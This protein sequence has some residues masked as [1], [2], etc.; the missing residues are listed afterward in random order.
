[1]FGI[2][3]QP[4]MQEQQGQN[5][6]GSRPSGGG[7]QEAIKVLS[8]RLPK[9][10]GAHGIAPMP[11]LTSE[12]S[13]GNPR[14]DSIVQQILSRMG[15]DAYPSAVPILGAAFGAS[16]TMPPSAPWGAQAPPQGPLAKPKIA[17]SDPTPPPQPEGAL[18]PRPVIDNWE[19]PY[20]APPERRE[21][22][23]I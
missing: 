23:V 17:F 16:N 12:G 5:G 20:P 14:V 18:F 15:V 3:F 10:V 2:N 1:M 9:V 11:L 8:L 22:Y 4:G 21:D 19:S 13:G 7:V 6:N